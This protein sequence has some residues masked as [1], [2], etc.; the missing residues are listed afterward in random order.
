M[1]TGSFAA[2]ILV[3]GIGDRNLAGDTGRGSEVWKIC[4]TIEDE[5]VRDVKIHLGEMRRK[6]LT[7]ISS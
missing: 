6:R 7:R 3:A 5:A 1:F 4:R 2:E